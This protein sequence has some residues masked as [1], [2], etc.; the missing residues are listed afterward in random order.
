[1]KFINDKLELEIGESYQFWENDYIEFKDGVLYCK[2]I[3]LNP[4][5]SIKGGV[6]ICRDII[7]NK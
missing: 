2:E 4:P 6:I 3:I 7:I 1:M 5:L